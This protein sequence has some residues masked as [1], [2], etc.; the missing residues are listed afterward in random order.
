[1]LQLSR[2]DTTQPERIDLAEW[3]E[4]FRTEFSATRQIP[5]DSIVAL[6]TSATVEVRMDPGHLHQVVWNLCENALRYADPETSHSPVELVSGRR[7]ANDRPF[8][9][10]RDRGPGIPA[11]IRDR[12]FEPFFRGKG[13]EKMGTGLGLFICRELCECN[14]AALVYE[15]REGG[16]SVFRIIFADPLRWER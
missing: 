11:D 7:L 13:S 4:H 10:I 5:E 9:E 12:I 16:G 14:R 3:V 1:V 6:A 15:P 2:R 8:L